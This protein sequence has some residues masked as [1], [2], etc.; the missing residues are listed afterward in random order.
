M[1]VLELENVSYRY[2]GAKTDSLRNVSFRVESGEM[3]SVEGQSGAGKSTLLHII[4]GLD[5]PREGYI[6]WDGKR[7]DDLSVYRRDTASLISQSYLLFPTRTVIEN[8]CYPMI[9]K[10]MERAKALKRAK[11]ILNYVGLHEKLYNTYPSKISGGERQRTAIARCVGASSKIIVADEPTGNL[12]DSN[13]EI[14]T[15]LLIG[16]CRE[17]NKIVIMATHNTQLAERADKHFYIS[18]GVLSERK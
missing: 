1:S 3:V 6:S 12:D 14:I 10:G 16:L 5:V 9:I 15:E 8:V 13:T 2:K 7:V 17:Q 11:S 4:A 18:E